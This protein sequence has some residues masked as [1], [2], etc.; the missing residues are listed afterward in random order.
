MQDNKDIVMLTNP[1][2]ELLFNA[3]TKEWYRETSMFSSISKKVMHPAY[4]QII[5]MGEQAVPLILHELQRRPAHW[6]EALR[7]ITGDSPVPPEHAG[8]VRIMAAD[9]IEWGKRRG[10]IT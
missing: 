2:M 8:I 3:L 5:G 9:W 10:Y 4:Q 6:F 7:A 1:A